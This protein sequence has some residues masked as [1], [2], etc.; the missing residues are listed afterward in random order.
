[1]TT[2]KIPVA[3][4]VVNSVPHMPTMLTIKETSHRSG[5]PESTLRKMCFKNEIIYIKRGRI[6]YINWD[7]FVDYL[8]GEM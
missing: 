8:N 7:R 3:P 4:T 6:T 5:F 1:M 2:D